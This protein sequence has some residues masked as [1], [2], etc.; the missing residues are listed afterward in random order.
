MPVH[1]PSRRATAE[2]IG[3][4]VLVATVVG[5][6]IMATRLTQDVALQLLV[7]AV[8]TVAALAVLIW[9]LGPISGAHFNPAVTLVA[10]ARK[11]IGAGE[12]ARYVVA[13]IVGGLAGTALG[14]LMFDLPAWHASTKVRSS[15]SLW[16]G[17]IVATAGLLSLCL[18]YTSSQ[19]RHHRARLH[20]SA[21]C[22]VGASA[23]AAAT[24]TPAAGGGRAGCVAGR[25]GGRGGGGH[26]GESE[27][28][29]SGRVR[30]AVHSPGELQEPTA[31]RVGASGD[32]DA[33][34]EGCLLYTSRCV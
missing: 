13:Q 5:S 12:A 34:D 16:L 8:A 2:A 26:R 4:A 1:E 33:V 6:G 21:V 11:E 30:G 3:T 29:A 9:S 22:R 19:E 25:A 23:A 27:V 10:L 15:A 17:E 24:A 20:H 7:N 14:N 28:D 32:G 18:L 31:G